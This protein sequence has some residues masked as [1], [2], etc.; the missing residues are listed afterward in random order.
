MTTPLNIGTRMISL[1]LIDPPLL[2]MRATFD[3]AAFADLKTSMAQHGLLQPIVVFLDG[4]RYRV[5][6][7]HR[8]SVAATDIGWTEIE[9]KVVTADVGI[10]ESMKIDENTRREQ[11]NAADEGEYL[12][13][14]LEKLCD[15]DIEQ[16]GR[17]TSLSFSYLSDR[18]NL[19][20]GDVNIVA[21]VRENKIGVGVAGEFNRIKSAASRFAALDTAVRYGCTV[22]QA[23]QL[24]SDYNL[25]FDRDQAAANGAPVPAPVPTSLESVGPLCVCCEDRRDIHE[26]IQIH[27]H[28]YCWKATL[29][30]YLDVLHGRVSAST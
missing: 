18:I 7:G 26:L 1:A 2:P 5:V 24:R 19:V 22:K 15:G 11:V 8:R 20:E 21:A 16:L 25:Q 30:K 28:S 23:R 14:L 17:L 27:V 9:C 29:S 6:A 12:K 10:L 13:V 4:E 3:D